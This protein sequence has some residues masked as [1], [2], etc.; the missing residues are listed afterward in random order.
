MLFRSP[1]IS[2][3]VNMKFAAHCS[4][5]VGAAAHGSLSHPRPRNAYSSPGT[6]PSTGG[7]LSC[8]G[9]ACFWY[10]VGCSIGCPKCNNVNVQKT[11]LYADPHCTAEEGLIEPTNNDPEFLTW[12]PQKDS[13]C[14][15]F[16]KYNPWRAPGKSPVND[17]CG[18]AS[19]FAD[20]TAGGEVPM[21]YQVGALGSQVLPATQ[22]TDRK[23]TRLNSSH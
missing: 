3:L 12:D 23:S 17:P 20:T 5:V 11:S 19:G 22:A 8:V 2:C 14:G 13:R 10:H 6:N 7:D 4:F 16:T 21:G 1:A 9:D 15:D 18:Q